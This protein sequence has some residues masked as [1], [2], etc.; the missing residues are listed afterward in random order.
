MRIL[1]LWF[2][3]QVSPPWALVLILEYFQERRLIFSN[4]TCFISLK[5]GLNQTRKSNSRVSITPLRQN[6]SLFLMNTDTDRTWLWMQTSARTR[7]WH[8]QRHRHWYG[9]RN[10][11]GHGHGHGHWRRHKY[12]HNHRNGHEQMFTKQSEDKKCE[13]SYPL[14]L[15]KSR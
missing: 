9:D 2:F 6:F 14:L 11:L 1:K 12:G 3:N 5:T 8:W 10:G 13:N 15:M 4:M 7:T